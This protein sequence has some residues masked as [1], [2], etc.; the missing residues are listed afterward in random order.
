MTFKLKEIFS[1]HPLATDHLLINV[2]FVSELWAAR[3]LEQKVAAGFAPKSLQSQADDEYRHALLLAKCMKVNGFAPIEDLTLAIQEMLYK[4]VCL[5]DL[6]HS[7]QDY[8]VFTGI[9]QILERRAVWVY[10]T[11]CN[12]GRIDSY[13]KLLR[14]L[15]REERPHIH[16]RWRPE[17]PVVKNI[18][19]MDRWLHREFLP[20]QYG[21]FDSI[22]NRRYWTEYYAGRIG[23]RDLNKT[24][25]EELSLQR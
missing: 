21:A 10:R 9:H 13:K 7:F 22:N 8:E 2:A 5:L 4:K 23:R 20:K 25:Q 1:E 16:Q 11:Y 3:D 17:H 12:G 14:Q 24:L 15:I 18:A 6:A 19:L